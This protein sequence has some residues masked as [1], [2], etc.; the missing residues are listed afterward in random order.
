MIVIDK[1]SAEEELTIRMEIRLV[2]QSI[3]EVSAL[4]AF[5]EGRRD[6]G[7]PL[8]IAVSSATMERVSVLLAAEL[9]RL[10]DQ[11]AP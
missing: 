10:T 8:P 1:R 11:A 3:R 2:E 6:A 5:A 7:K 4:H 9:L